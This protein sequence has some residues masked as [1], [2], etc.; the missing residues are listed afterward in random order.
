MNMDILTEEKILTKIIELEKKKSDLNQK[1]QSL[2]SS[3]SSAWN[4]Y[5]SELCA[6]SMMAEEKNLSDKIAEVDRNIDIL[7]SFFDGEFILT[8]ET[9][10]KKKLEIIENSKA[11]LKKEEDAINLLLSKFSKFRELLDS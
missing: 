11:T 8:E 5:G 1:L 6:G 7:T 9:I 3:N 2:I 4:T 10:L